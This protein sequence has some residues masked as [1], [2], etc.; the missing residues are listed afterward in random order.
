MNYSNM[1]QSFELLF[2]ACTKGFE[3][4]DTDLQS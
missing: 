2:A 3:E 1:H 4:A